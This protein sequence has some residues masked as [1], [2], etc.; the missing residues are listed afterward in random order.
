MR[1]RVMIAMALACDPKLIIA[2]EPTTALDVTIQAQILELMK[3]MQKRYHMSMILI[4][5]D[6]SVIAE[7]VDEVAV[8]YAGVIVER[9]DVHRIFSNPLHPYTQGLLDSIPVLGN[10]EKRLHAIKG[11]VPNLINLPKGCFFANR[12]PQVKPECLERLP[13]LI[14]SE[15]GHQ[16]RCVLY[17][18][19]S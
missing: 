1:Q 7:T 3:D 8:M 14:E 6:L 5:H 19:K 4:T 16:V 13:D 17:K 18:G 9:C 12:C 15:A 2:D 11:R 10:T